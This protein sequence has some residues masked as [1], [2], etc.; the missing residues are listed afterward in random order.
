MFL[1]PASVRGAGDVVNEA[2][3]HPLPIPCRGCGA[4]AAMVVTD[5]QHKTP[6]LVIKQ[7]HH[8]VLHTNT[9]TLEDLQRMFREHEQQNGARQ[10]IT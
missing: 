10:D 3:Y 2:D 4:L 5:D 1:L 9:Y 8:G 6:L 7:R